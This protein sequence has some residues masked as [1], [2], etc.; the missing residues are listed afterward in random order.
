M[1]SSFLFFAQAA[2]NAV[3]SAAPAIPGGVT[4]EKIDAGGFSP[5]QWVMLGV[6][7][8]VSLGLIVSVISQT[9]KSESLAASMM[10]GGSQAPAPY[11]GKKSSED[12]LNQIANT[13]AALF[14]G[15]SILM[16]FVFN[17]A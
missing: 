3:D 1:F 10:G 15:L 2:A 5:W 17:R 11:K 16:V 13:C 4:Y 7:S 9:H 12:R 8:L 14:I 6:Y